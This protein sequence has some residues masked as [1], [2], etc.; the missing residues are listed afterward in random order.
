[1]RFILFS[2]FLLSFGI[3][4]QNHEAF[5]RISKQQEEE[6]KLLALFVE[7]F[8]SVENLDSLTRRK[9]GSLIRSQEMKL[10]ECHDLN[11]ERFAMGGSMFGH[12]RLLDF[13]KAKHSVFNKYCEPY[14]WPN[15]TFNSSR[16]L[17]NPVE[18][19]ENWVQNVRFV[20]QAAR[21]LEDLNPDTLET[22]QNLVCEND[23]VLVKVWDGFDS[24]LDLMD[25]RIA[26]WYLSTG[27]VTEIM[28]YSY[29]VDQLRAP[30]PFN[31]KSG[32]PGLMVSIIGIKLFLEMIR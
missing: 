17:D 4:A 11:F 31:P 7:T 27:E 15:N 1:M 28:G 14:I 22:V 32:V 8:R 10:Y 13:E 16:G 23:Y 12:L 19:Y 25:L 9:V 26:D 30:S 2:I 29:C 3:F 18:H 5:S 6:R 24:Y 21:K 20:L